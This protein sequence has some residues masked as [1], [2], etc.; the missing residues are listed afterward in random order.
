[1][2]VVD[3]A[4]ELE[5]VHETLHVVGRHIFSGQGYFEDCLMIT[6]FMS[7]ISCPK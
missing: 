7:L 6:L 2:G 3:L 4:Q 5:L 1:V